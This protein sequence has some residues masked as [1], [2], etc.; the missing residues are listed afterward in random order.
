[1]ATIKGIE[2]LGE[3]ASYRETGTAASG[4][5]EHGPYHCEDCLHKPAPD[6]PYCTHPKVVADKELKSRLVQLD[7]QSVVKIDMER[8]CCKF[9]N[10]PLEDEDEDARE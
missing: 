2:K 7:G 10:Q 1:M 8:G 4:Y 9:V 3:S 5:E 6:S